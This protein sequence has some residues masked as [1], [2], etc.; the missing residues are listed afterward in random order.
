VNS[1]AGYALRA[2]GKSLVFSIVANNYNS[3]AAPVRRVIDWIAL[4][5]L[6]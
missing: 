1:L 2:D 4:A 6:E 3:P 5:L